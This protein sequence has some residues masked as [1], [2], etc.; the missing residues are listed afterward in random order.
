MLY[1]HQKSRGNTHLEGQLCQNGNRGTITCSTTAHATAQVQ[2]AAF[3]LGFKTNRST[4]F[5]CLDC[6]VSLPRPHPGQ[7]TTG[8]CRYTVHVEITVASC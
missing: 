4:S 7:L 5:F 2:D 8:V 1:D 3:T 6:S